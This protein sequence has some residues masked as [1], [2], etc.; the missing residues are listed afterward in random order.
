MAGT[1]REPMLEMGE[2]LFLRMGYAGVGL[3]DVLSALKTSKGGFYHFFESK[4]RFAEAVMERYLERRLAAMEAHFSNTTSLSGFLTWFRD[5]WRAQVAADYVPRCLV[6]RFASDI[7]AGYPLASVQTGY[8]RLSATFSEAV[9]LGQK[10]GWLYAEIQPLVAAN[11]LIN[12]WQ[13]ATTRARV[14]LHDTAP[15]AALAHLEA[16]LKP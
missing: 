10:A 6:A 2:D 11:H 12:L 16:W 3:R 14:E 4:E 1:L 15:M 7:G 13:G 8:D 5:D 9:G